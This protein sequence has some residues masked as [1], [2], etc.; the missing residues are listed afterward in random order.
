MKFG[1]YHSNFIEIRFNWLVLVQCLCFSVLYAV[2]V[3][4][5]TIALRNICLGLGALLS[6]YPIYQARHF[7]F[8]REAIPIWLLIGLFI[9]AIF[10]LLVLSQNPVLQYEEFISIWKRAILSAIF[11]LG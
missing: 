9:W 5:G 7:F 11:A 3:L 4:P 2:W 10:H 1:S 6:V 8:K